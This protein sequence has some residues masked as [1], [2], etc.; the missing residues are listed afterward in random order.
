[1]GRGNRDTKTLQ[2][3]YKYTQKLTV[4]WINILQYKQYIIQS[5][6]GHERVIKNIDHGYFRLKSQE[7][8]H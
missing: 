7:T 1:M 6:N 5:A 2:A 8:V 3:S 4:S